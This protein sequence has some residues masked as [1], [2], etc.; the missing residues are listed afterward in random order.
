MPHHWLGS[1]V[2][3]LYK[4]G[5]PYQAT[6]YRP[7]ALL[8][9][10]YKLVAAFTCRRLQQQTF[11]H[12]LLS[13][14]EHGDL[15]RH[16][17]ADHKYHLQRLY[18]GSKSSY[19]LYID[20][21]KAFNS[22]PLS[23][24]WTVLEHSN[25]S[26][27]AITSVKNPYASPVD[28][29]IINGHCP[30]SYVQACGLRQGCPL[31][32]LLFILS[33]NALFPY[34][35]ATTPPPEPGR[36]T[37][38]HAFIDDILIRSEDPS[39]SQRAINF[40]DG[41]ARLWG[42]D[43]NVQKTENQAMGQAV[44][45]TFATAAGSSFPTFNPKPSRPRTHYKY[46]GGYIFTQHQ[47]EGLDGM[48][49]SE[50]LSYFPRLSPLPLTL[51][52]RIR[53][54]NSQLIPAVT[55][56]LSAHPLPPRG[57]CLAGRLHLVR[58]SKAIHDTPGPSRTGMPPEPAG[59]LPSNA[60]PTASIQQPFISLCVPS[61]AGPHPQLVASS[62]TPYVAQTSK[63]QT[64]FKTQSWT[65]RTPLASPSTPSAPGV[66]AYMSTSWSVPRSQ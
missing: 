27:A 45:G 24:L 59:V 28:A 3:L 17:C 42:L 13:P 4:R 48:T 60:W 38:D 29:P 40:F 21:N 16:Q 18:A 22:V 32:F 65:L 9:T 47:A 61:T 51:S 26:R 7:I 33:F 56:R 53:L 34:F 12:S 64:S 57:Y 14:I 50:I 49:R 55:Y 11:S 5:D 31:S 63:V 35:L 46:L 15:P 37:S 66:P 25:L 20:F 2:C 41:P 6:N 62:L 30:H 36:V 23:T 8:N 54:V 39:Y 52:E 44:Q 58:P 1:H 19:S 10:V 43:M